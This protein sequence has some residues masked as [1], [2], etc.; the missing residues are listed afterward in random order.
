MAKKIILIHGRDTM[1]AASAHEELC[2][3]ALVNG[4][5]RVDPSAAQRL[6]QEPVEIIFAYFGDI[7]NELISSSDP[8]AKAELTA[9]NDQLYGFEPCLDAG[10]YS[11]PLQQLMQIN[12][13]D[14]LAYGSLVDHYR[15]GEWL[16]EAA[17][18]VSRVASVTA[19]S[20]YVIKWATAD[21]SQYLHT[22]K[23]GSE[24]RERL[25]SP[26]KQSLLDQDD[27][28]LISHSMGAI[29]SYDVLWKFSRMS[30]YRRVQQSGNQINLWLT[31]G[32]PLGEPGVRNNLYD[33]NERGEDRFPREIVKRWV[34]IAAEDDYVAHDATMANDFAEMLELGYVEKIIDRQ[35]Y[36]FWVKNERL[37][38]HNLFGYLDHPETAKFLAQWI[39]STSEVEFIDPI[40]TDSSFVAERM[41]A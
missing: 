3:A 18:I 19:L 30:E 20:E 11:A 32:S 31:L 40:P 29:V 7:S 21:M 4:L 39:R 14:G 8:D 34:N 36:N 27:I 13:H 2:A 22:R 26:L 17:A 24:V 1:P 37:N 5:Q 15:S 23:V 25:Q 16:D 12:S 9:R 28:C 33:A 38:P 10:M 6:Q 35:I 41:V